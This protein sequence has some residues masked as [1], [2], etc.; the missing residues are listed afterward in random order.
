M[1]VS[2]LAKLKSFKTKFSKAEELV[3]KRNRERELTACPPSKICRR[4]YTF[5]PSASGGSLVETI[6]ITVIH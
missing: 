6:N 2:N 1:K 5:E 3:Q 4:F